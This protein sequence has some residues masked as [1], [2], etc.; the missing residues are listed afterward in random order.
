MTL[1][2]HYYTDPASHIQYER[3]KSCNGCSYKNGKSDRCMIGGD[4]YP[5]R[6][7]QYK[8]TKEK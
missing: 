7:D 8:Q 5:K 4:S 2:A 6:C 3:E 1:P